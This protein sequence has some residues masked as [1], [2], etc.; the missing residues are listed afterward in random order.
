MLGGKINVWSNNGDD[1][2][3]WPITIKETLN[4]H[5]SAPAVCD[6]DGDGYIEMVLNTED[7]YTYVFNHDG[8]VLEGW[9][10]F[11]P[12]DPTCYQNICRHQR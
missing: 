7:D 11:I 12:D 2:S 1:V 3:G 8:T 10:I 4:E 6:L 5:P 9:P